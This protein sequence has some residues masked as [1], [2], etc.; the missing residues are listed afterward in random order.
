[1]WLIYEHKK[2]SKQLEE[3]PIDLLKKY[4]KWKA[5]VS[6]SGPDGLKLIKG[7][8]DEALQGKWRGHRSSRLNLQYRIIY[9][10]ERERIL[11]QVLRVTPHD[12][13]RT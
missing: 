10:V 3:L 6:F 12:Y 11:V 7:F 4:E 5:I 9:K 13:R 8:H 1:M 2:A